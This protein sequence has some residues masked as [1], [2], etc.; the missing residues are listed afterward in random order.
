MLKE[1]RCL[2]LKNL[3][4]SGQSQIYEFDYL[5]GRVFVISH[6]DSCKLISHPEL[7]GLDVQKSLY[8]A[9]ADFL[10]YLQNNG[11]LNKINI[12]NI[13]RGGLNF[14]LE[15]ACVSLDSS[16]PD[17][18][19][20]SSERMSS[21]KVSYLQMKYKKVIPSLGSSVLVGDIIA[22]GSTLINTID[23]LADC[24]EKSGLYPKNIVVFTI[25]KIK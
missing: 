1:L 21:G 2:R 3:S 9:T 17:V 14:P 15:N 10:L 11:F 18:S 12:V 24:Y 5:S 20:V 25:N 7:V 22:S 6:E 19:F 13:L 23:Y 4:T 16:I 8:H